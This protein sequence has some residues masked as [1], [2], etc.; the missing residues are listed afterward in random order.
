MT[1]AVCASPSPADNKGKQLTQYK[2]EPPHNVGYHRVPVSS[3]SYSSL[4][5]LS[6]P[7]LVSANG[8]QSASAVRAQ[9]KLSMFS[10]SDFV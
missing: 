5:E 7:L 9:D 10:S 1:D 4:K 3:K 6:E 2:H 8:T